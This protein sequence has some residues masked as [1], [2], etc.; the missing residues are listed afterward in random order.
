MHFSQKFENSYLGFYS[1]QDEHYIFWY[2]D[3]ICQYIPI[4]SE[5][6]SMKTLNKQ[7]NNHWS[8]AQLLSQIFL[9]YRLLSSFLLAPEIQ[10]WT[11]T[12]L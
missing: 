8:N 10:G 11:F 12:E 2:N 9:Y 7:N 3:F 4:I 5:T 1:E 6:N